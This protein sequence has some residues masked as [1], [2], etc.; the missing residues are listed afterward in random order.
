[1]KKEIMV[2]SEMAS[3]KKL[4]RGTSPRAHINR[5]RAINTRSAARRLYVCIL[6]FIFLYAFYPQETITGMDFSG[7]MVMAST[8][9]YIRQR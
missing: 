2:R 6:V 9:Q 1:M 4:R 3:F 8:G 7:E 5:G